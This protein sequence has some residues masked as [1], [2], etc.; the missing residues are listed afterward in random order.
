V[1]CFLQRRP[2]SKVANIK[3]LHSGQKLWFGNISSVELLGYEGELKWS[4][5]EKGLEIQFLGQKP[6]QFAYVL[7]IK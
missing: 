3:S 4:R 5:N 6:Y 7:K 2:E 1:I